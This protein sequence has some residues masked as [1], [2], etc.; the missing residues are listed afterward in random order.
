MNVSDRV[1]AR[2]F[3]AHGIA[4]PKDTEL[5]RL[6]GGQWARAHG[7]W[8]WALWSSSQPSQTIHG[9]QYPATELLKCKNWSI[10]QPNRV[11]E[12]LSIWPCNTCQKGEVGDCDA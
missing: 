5:R 7:R 10:D 12:D 9:S 11:S 2:L 6:G 8:S 4:L 3:L 1:F